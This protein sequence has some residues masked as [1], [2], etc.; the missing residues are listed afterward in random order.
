MVCL[1]PFK[2]IIPE[3][4]EGPRGGGGGGSGGQ[5]GR[6]TVGQTQAMPRAHM[7]SLK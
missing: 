1:F 4:A 3:A 7:T 6:I 2:D 5:K